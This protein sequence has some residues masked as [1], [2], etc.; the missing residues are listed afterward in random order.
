MIL[1]SEELFR[2][3]TSS[4]RLTCEHGV[5]EISFSHLMLTQSIFQAQQH[6]H[7][8]SGNFPGHIFSITMSKSNQF[9][10]AV[11]P[12]LLIQPAHIGQGKGVRDFKV[13]YFLLYSTGNIIYSLFWSVK[14]CVYSKEYPD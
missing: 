1:S 12:L 4:R 11:Y 2:K 6:T 3:L 5:L 8:L 10:I 13:S 7:V 14:T 9:I